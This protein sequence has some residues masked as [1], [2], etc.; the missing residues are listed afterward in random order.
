MGSRGLAAVAV[1]VAIHLLNKLRIRR[2]RWAA[3]Q[4][5]RDSV[6]RNQRRLQIEDL[7]LL[8]LRC[9]IVVA[10]V[11]AFAR[12]VLQEM[13]PGSTLS[14]EGPASIV[15][16]LDNSASMG[17]SNGISSRFEEGRKAIRESLEQLPP[18]P[19]SLFISF[20]T[21][22]SRSPLSHRLTSLAS[23]AV[24]SSPRS[25]IAR[26][27]WSEA[28]ARRMRPSDPSE[29]AGGK[30]ASTR[31]A[32]LQRGGISEKSKSCSRRTPAST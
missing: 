30:S 21:G 20:P 15:V 2:T 14:G 4:F 11:L 10:L 1:P 9:L 6:Q 13:V 22:W 3:M 18:E 27:I 7:L 8:I 19:S 5:V 26:P 28:Y 32:R 31:T 25:Q 29:A 17:Q 23:G 16:L 24:W 12:P